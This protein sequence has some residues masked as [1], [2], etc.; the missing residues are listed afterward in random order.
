METIGDAG[1]S[2][3]WPAFVVVASAVFL[4]ILDLFVVNIALPA[5]SDAFPAA[6]L[7]SVT[8]IVTAYA[9]VFAVALVPAGKLGDLYGR[10]RWF[11]IGLIAFTV[12]SLTAAVA[13]SVELLVVGRVVQGLGAA[14]VTPNSLAIA[15]SLFPPS[16]RASVIAAWGVIAG[17][18]ATAGPIAGALL[19]EADWRWIFL[20]NVP[21]GLAVIFVLPR[22]VGEIRTEGRSPL[23]D[24]LGALLLGG[25]VGLI[26]VGLSQGSEWGWDVR[27]L[28]AF[29]VAVALAIAFVWRSAHHPAPIVELSLLRDP[30]FGLALVAAL[31]FWSGFAALLLSSGLFLTG[32]WHQSVMQAGFAFAP[33]PAAT[34]IFSAASPRLAQRFGPMPVGT[35]GGV[36]LAA[37]ALWLATQLSNDAGGYLSIFLPAQIVAGAGAGLALTTLLTVAVSGLPA[38]RLST[39]TA[40]YTTFRQVGAALGVAIWVALVGSSQLSSA[41]AFTLGWFFIAISGLAT[42]GCALLAA[43]FGKPAPA[44]RPG[45]VLGDPSAGAQ[46]PIPDRRIRGRPWIAPRDPTIDPG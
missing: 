37:G 35:L 4:T 43:R 38:N 17:L 40:V 31:A 36:L 14:A 2:N 11:S 16:G 30:Q 6:S 44:C 20:L 3:P 25:S 15:L 39:G 10:R 7:A 18:G 23:P 26:T 33:G 13:P 28:A 32:A 41:V 12:G 1:R 45:E 29:V 42:A 9:I 27:V 34:A 8:W 21:I 46:V 5:I 22:M 19:A 24:G